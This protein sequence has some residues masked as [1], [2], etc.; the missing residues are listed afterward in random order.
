[1]SLSQSFLIRLCLIKFKIIYL[2]SDVILIRDTSAGVPTNAPIPPAVIPMAA[3]VK[4]LGGF[5]E[6]LKNQNTIII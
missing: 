3:F 5:P 4:K 1:M 2:P 6:S